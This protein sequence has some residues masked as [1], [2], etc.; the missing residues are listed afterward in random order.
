MSSEGKQSLQVIALN[1]NLQMV[2]I[3]NLTIKAKQKPVMNTFIL[4]SDLL[5]NNLPTFC[6]L[7]L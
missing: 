1:S 6:K 4:K 3:H 7:V 2:T 5:L